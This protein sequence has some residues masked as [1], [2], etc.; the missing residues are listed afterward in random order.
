MIVFLIWLK[1]S[2]SLVLF[3]LSL[4][5]LRQARKSMHLAKE[6]SDLVSA[7]QAAKMERLD[8]EASR[9]LLYR[10]KHPQRNGRV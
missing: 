7:Q 9:I 8:K 4:E 10:C 6:M 1:I 2:L 5:L 3:V